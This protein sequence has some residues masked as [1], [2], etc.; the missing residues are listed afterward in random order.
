MLKNRVIK[1]KRESV[2]KAIQE[3]KRKKFI[4]KQS[5]FLRIESLF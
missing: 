5:V 3:E 1:N 4:E 2:D